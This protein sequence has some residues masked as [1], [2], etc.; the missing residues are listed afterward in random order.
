[1]IKYEVNCKEQVGDPVD[2]LVEERSLSWER[3][4]NI[5]GNYGLELKLNNV[6]LTASQIFLKNLLR[7]I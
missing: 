1:M 4:I 7:N 5:V 3:Q 6:P 2:P